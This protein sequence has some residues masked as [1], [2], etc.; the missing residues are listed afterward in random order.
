MAKAG[1]PL[2]LPGIWTQAAACTAEGA[3][4]KRYKA[5]LGLVLAMPVDLDLRAGNGGRA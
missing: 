1:S 4:G 2:K 5:V 3:R